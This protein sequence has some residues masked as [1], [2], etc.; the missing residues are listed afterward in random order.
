MWTQLFVLLA[1]GLVV[2]SWSARVRQEHRRAESRGGERTVRRSLVA[3]LVLT[4]ASWWYVGV[5]PWHVW[6]TKARSG[7][8]DIARQAWPPRL[9]RGGAEALLSATRETV[10]MAV[11]AIFVAVLFAAPIAVL[12][13][14]RSGTSLQGRVVSA[15]ARFSALLARTI[16]PT[17]WALLVL[18]VV[19]PGSL[20]GGIA[21]GIY[22]FGVLVRLFG[23]ALENVDER[24]ARALRQLGAGR[25]VV[26]SYGSL[27]E[28]VPRW[29]AF[30]LYRW[31]VAARES[32]VVGLVGAGGLG[33]LIAKQTTSFDYRSMIVTI[34]AVMLLT[35]VVDL[36]SASARRSLR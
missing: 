6:A 30:S 23:D 25:A 29:T 19:F 17:V 11:I 14:R 9:P 3:V 1:L 27:P 7:V 36:V 34:A 28:V 22:T 4:V 18:F 33:R 26:F 31:E 20:P 13:A 15:L 24:P 8:R 16:P 5:R 2:E 32:V 10:Q 21:L 35:F 12:G